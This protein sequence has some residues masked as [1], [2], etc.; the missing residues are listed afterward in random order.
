MNQ[1][2]LSIQSFRFYCLCF[3]V[4]CSFFLINATQGQA[5]TLSSPS[6]TQK[7]SKDLVYKDLADKAFGQG[8]YQKALDWL[9]KAYEFSKKPRYIANKG[10][11]FK[12]MKRYRKYNE[13]KMVNIYREMKRKTDEIYEKKQLKISKN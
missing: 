6:P 5:Q 11:V 3:L 7:K 9:Q 4:L 10:M 13:N 8:E 12:Y 2:T 1:Y